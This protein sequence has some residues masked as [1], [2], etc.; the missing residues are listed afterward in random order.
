MSELDFDDEELVPPYDADDE[1]IDNMYEYFLE[2]MI[3]YQEDGVT[4]NCFY[5]M[6]ERDYTPE[7]LQ[8]ALR[9]PNEW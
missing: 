5:D 2:F 7:A 3:L 8:E 6:I 4:V 9:D 1:Y